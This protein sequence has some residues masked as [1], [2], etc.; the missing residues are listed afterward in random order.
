MHRI[1]GL[2]HTHELDAVTSLGEIHNHSD[3]SPPVLIYV[4]R[5]R[6][7]ENDYMQQPTQQL[8]DWRGS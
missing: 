1:F 7:A 5:I 4:I 8:V 3:I 2:I 6:D